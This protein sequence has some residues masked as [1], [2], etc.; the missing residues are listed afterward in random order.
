MP[1]YDVEVNYTCQTTYSTNFTVTAKDKDEAESKALAEA[2]KTGVTGEWEQDED[3]GDY[4]VL[5]VEEVEGSD[6]E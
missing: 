3:S 4:E 5:S 2:A 1:K 6:A